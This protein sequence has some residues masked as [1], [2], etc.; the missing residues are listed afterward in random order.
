[1][2]KNRYI[3]HLVVLFLLFVFAIGNLL[4]QETSRHSD[5]AEQL[6][7]CLNT[8]EGRKTISGTMA[9]VNWNLNEAKCCRNCCDDDYSDEERALDVE[10]GKDSHDD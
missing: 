7:K 1:M 8:I 3:K 6:I 4:A 2:L 9:C 5:E 10:G